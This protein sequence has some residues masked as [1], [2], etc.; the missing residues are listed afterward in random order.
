MVHRELLGSAKSGAGLCVP[1]ALHIQ[2]LIG[3]AAFT[4]S[5]VERTNAILMIFTIEMTLFTK[6]IIISMQSYRYCVNHKY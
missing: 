6:I 4:S 1:A 3:S 5:F 2:I